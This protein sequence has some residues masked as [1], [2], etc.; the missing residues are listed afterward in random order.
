MGICVDPLSEEELPFS[1]YT[2]SPL[3]T[4][5]KPIGRIGLILDLSYPNTKKVE[6]V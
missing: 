1:D 2:V 6:L 5:V 3:T 4:R